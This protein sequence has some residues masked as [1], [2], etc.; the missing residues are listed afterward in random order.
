[1]HAASFWFV[2]GRNHRMSELVS[3]VAYV[4]CLFCV[5]YLSLYSRLGVRFNWNVLYFWMISTLLWV[6]I[7]YKLLQRHK[8]K[9]VTDELFIEVEFEYACIK[10]Y[11]KTS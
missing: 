3:K 8:N 6:L 10:Y 1:M 11:Q 9:L 4:F 5:A 7:A 2:V